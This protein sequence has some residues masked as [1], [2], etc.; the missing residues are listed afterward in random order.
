MSAWWT[1]KKHI[2]LI[3]TAAIAL[4][5][6]QPQDAT[7]TGQMLRRG[8]AR[9]LENRYGDDMGQYRAEIEGYVFCPAPDENLPGVNI[10]LRSYNYQSC[11]T[12]S[13]DDTDAAKFVERMARAIEAKLGMT[14][15]ELWLAGRPYAHGV[16]GYWS[17]EEWPELVGAI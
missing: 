10:A 15:N 14:E 11:E 16:G 5:V 12:A 13:Y 1:S 7:E 2:D 6:I 3:V 8:N 17:Y 9:S 4:K